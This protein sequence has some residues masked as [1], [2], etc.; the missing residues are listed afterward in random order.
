M[1][2]FSFG[3]NDV[4]AVRVFFVLVF[5]ALTV[6]QIYQQMPNQ[7]GTTVHALQKNFQ[8]VFGFTLPLFHGRGLLNCMRNKLSLLAVSVPPDLVH[9]ITS[10]CC[11]TVGG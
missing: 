7:K 5:R 11:L 9:Q 1:P 3:E 4:S 10:G 2:V 6:R 8:N